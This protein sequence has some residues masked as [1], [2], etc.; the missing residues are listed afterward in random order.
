MLH[1]VD[2][3]AVSPS[4]HQPILFSDGFPSKCSQFHQSDDF[5]DFFTSGIWLSEHYTNVPKLA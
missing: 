5:T 2:T 1:Q 4:V 3:I